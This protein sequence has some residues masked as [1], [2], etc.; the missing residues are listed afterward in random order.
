[1]TAAPLSIPFADTPAPGHGEMGLYLHVPFCLRKCPYCSFFSVAGARELHGG[2]VRAVKGQMARML[3]S[4]RI[5]DHKVATVFVGGGTPSILAPD[6]LTD[7]LAQFHD[8]FIMAAGEVETSIEVNPATVGYPE[9]VQL[10]RG[11]FNRISIGVQ[12]LA[13]RELRELGR[14]HTADDALRTIADARKAGFA[15]LN[16][17]LMY[18]LPG[19]TVGGWEKTLARALAEGPDHLA[20]YELTIEEGT[21]FARQQQQGGLELPPEDAVLDM[22]AATAETIAGAGFSRYEISNY[23]RPGRECCHNLNYWRNGWYVGLGPGAVSCLAGRRYTA[24]AD[25]GEYCRRIAAGEEWW[26]DEE[27]LD[28][29]ARFRET[30]VMG[31]R[32]TDGISLAELRRRF[33]LNVSEYYG[34]ALR[35]LEQHCLVAVQGD[36]LRLTPAGMNLANQVMV[37]LV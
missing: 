11:G 34:D 8:G 19:Q 30:V 29:E 36:R 13:D 5:G 1:M 32:M 37:R 31:L 27:E 12:S 7:L 21:P 10:S 3:E 33:G 22:M 25:V 24:V 14:P 26:S 20:L 9:L 18:G 2:Y 4:G 23:A 28:P 6:K 16:I 15:N 35:Q 17:D